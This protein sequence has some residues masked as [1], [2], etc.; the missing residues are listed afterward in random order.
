M[1]PTTVGYR[2]PCK[3]DSCNKQRW[4]QGYCQRCARLNGLC[5]FPQ[6]AIEGCTRQAQSAGAGSICRPCRQT[7]RCNTEDCGYPPRG[8]GYCR[9]CQ[10]RRD[11]ANKPTC[12]VEQCRNAGQ[13]G[14]GEAWCDKHHR[15]PNACTQTGCAQP[16]LEDGVC[17]AHATTSNKVCANTGC[18]KPRYRARLCYRHFQATLANE[19]RHPV[20]RDRTTT[21]YCGVH[22]IGI[23]FAAGD[24]FDWVAVERIFQGRLDGRQPTI[25]ELAAALRLAERRHV[26]QAELGRR[27]GLDE[28]MWDAWRG[29]VSRLTSTQAA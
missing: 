10:R 4:K 14:P 2:G 7:A 13:R 17:A 21:A 25:L 28:R 11:K 26:P 29:Q 3:T 12:Q 8:D 16:I 20:C 24:W 5:Q 18:P 9:S 19:C 6:C 15:D 27:L 22:D 23:D 1:Q